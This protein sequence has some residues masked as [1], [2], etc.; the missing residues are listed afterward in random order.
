MVG[1]SH[2][3]HETMENSARFDLETAIQDWRESLVSFPAFTRENRDE[4][5][6]HLRDS[7]S[8]LQSKG[9]SP[10]EAFWIARA[11]LGTLED[12]SAE[13]AKCHPE[14]LWVHRALWMIV[15]LVVISSITGLVTTCSLLCT[16]AYLA[17]AN[18]LGWPLS[19]QP[20][21]LALSGTAAPT[22]GLSTLSIAIYLAV[23]FGALLCIWRWGQQGVVHM[24]RWGL[25]MRS[26]PVAA[27][28]VVFFAFAVNLLSSTAAAALAGRALGPVDFAW[29]M[30]I[31][32][33][34]SAVIPAI[35]WP[36]LVG[37]LVA[38]A[39]RPSR[40]AGTQSV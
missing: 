37:W 26:K 25:T 8:T 30:A 35:L 27:G 6:S 5:E 36:V 23:A 4:L 29:T 24:Q 40:F 14:Q 32:S 22:P 1:R 2:R 15:G 9:L 17:V 39:R 10:T 33:M 38:R 18:A 12:L 31:R 11:R 28:F 3:A 34:G 7:L 21:S 13:Y 19:A 20:E 16:V